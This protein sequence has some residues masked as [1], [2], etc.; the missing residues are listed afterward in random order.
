ME[1][2]RMRR[3]LRRVIYAAILVFALVGTLSYVVFLQGNDF[4]G[5]THRFFTISRGQTFFT[6]VDSLE[7][8]GLIE[9]RRWFMLASKVLGGTEHIRVGR[10][11]FESGVSNTTIFESLRDGKNLVLISLTISEGRRSRGIAKILSLSL[12][13]DS[14]RFARLVHERASG[15]ILGIQAES[16][17][18]YLFPE[19]Y[20][21]HWQTDE[22][23]IIKAMVRQFEL[24]FPDSLRAS[25]ER[26]GWDMNEVVTMASIIQGEAMM[27]DEMPRISGVYHNRLRKGMKLQAD[28][29]IQFLIE[30]GPRRVL[31]SDLAVKSPYNTYLYKGLPPGPV[32]NPGRVALLAA[33]YPESHDFLFFVADGT[34]R[35]QFTRTYAEHMRHVRLYRK[36]RNE[37]LSN[38]AENKKSLSVR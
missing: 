27:V 11:R 38:E 5:G 34:G 29:T 2:M 35:H 26:L 28:P 24:A 10:Y 14:L 16:L 23:E 8:Q 9:N 37:M 25:T 15:T 33:V 4:D 6:V 7:A 18:G 21:F 32:N 3:N 13:I 30:N 20:S 19:T 1:E 17:E 31:Y 36:M 12:G 22:S